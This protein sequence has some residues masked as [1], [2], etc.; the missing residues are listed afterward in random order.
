MSDELGDY[1]AQAISQLRGKQ[2]Q[3]LTA[4]QSCSGWN[5]A[6]ETTFFDT[7]N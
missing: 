2:R 7:L 1:V 6:G 3:A 4:P 5:V